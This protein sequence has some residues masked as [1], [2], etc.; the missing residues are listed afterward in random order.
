MNRRLPIAAAVAL[1]A[2]A[3]LPRRQP[4]AATGG[5]ARPRLRPPR[6]GRQARRRAPA[7]RAVALPPRV[8]VREAAAALRR[9]PRVAYAAP[10][11]IAT[12]SQRRAAGRPDSQRP[13]PARP[14]RPA[15]PAAG[16]RSSGTSCPGRDRQR[17]CCPSRPAAST[18]SAPGNTWRGRTPAAPRAS[19][20]AVLDTGIAYRPQGSRFRRSPDFTSGQFVKGY[21]FVDD[22]RAAARRKRPRHPRRRDDRREDQQ[23]DRPDRARLPGE[24]DAGPR[25]R[26]ARP[27]ARPTTSPGASASPS[28]TAPT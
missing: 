11:Y 4:Q 2:G 8:G 6:G 9:S 25:P 3:R 14:G 28:P 24:A 15:R 13:R 18:R 12:A 23:R 17:R 26:R 7:A 20:V 19:T 5:R 22:D 27:R 21:D 16:S 10:N 1:L